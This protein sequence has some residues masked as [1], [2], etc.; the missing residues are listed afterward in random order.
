MVGARRCLGEPSA[1]SAGQT[2]AKQRATS[3][4]QRCPL[5]VPAAGEHCRGRNAVIGGYVQE[6]TLNSERLFG[7]RDHLTQ[8]A[9]ASFKRLGLARKAEAFEGSFSELCQV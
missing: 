7:P 4:P 6:A 2:L 3:L 1:G 5:A 8:F 9:E